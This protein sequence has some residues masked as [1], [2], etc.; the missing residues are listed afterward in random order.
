VSA[1]DI[2]INT[3]FTCACCVSSYPRW[4]S[5]AGRRV[6]YRV[7]GTLAAE[8]SVAVH[9]PRAAC[10]LRLGLGRRRRLLACLQRARAGPRRRAGRRRRRLR[11]PAWRGAGPGRHRR[12]QALHALCACPTAQ[13]AEL[14]VVRVAVRHELERRWG[15]RGGGGRGLCRPAVTRPHRLAGWRS[16]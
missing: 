10:A 9:V 1:P 4:G 6:M 2:H 11:G 7:V 15:W 14:R 12:P 16:E 5:T 8:L 13:A 3:F